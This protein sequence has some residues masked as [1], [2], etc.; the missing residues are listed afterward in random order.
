MN[1]D[2]ARTWSLGEVVYLAWL[3]VIALVW[4]GLPM[5]LVLTGA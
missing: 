2:A 1:E 5:A 4:V 3:T